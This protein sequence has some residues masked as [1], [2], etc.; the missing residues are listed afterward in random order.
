MLKGDY[1]TARPSAGYE[2]RKRT[3]STNRSKKEVLVPVHPPIAHGVIRRPRRMSFRNRNGDEPGEGSI[4]RANEPR[5]RSGFMSVVVGTQA[6]Y[7]NP[8][9]RRQC[10]KCM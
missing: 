7:S 9:R 6:G 3:A 10:I 2:L 5:H 4:G 8:P 1:P